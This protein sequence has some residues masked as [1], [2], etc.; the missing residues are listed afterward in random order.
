MPSFPSFI[1]S[2]WPPGAPCTLSNLLEESHNHCDYSVYCL[3][4]SCW[5]APLLHPMRHNDTSRRVRSPLH[6]YA[7]HYNVIHI[8]LG[9]KRSHSDFIHIMLGIKL[10]RSAI[11]NIQ[12]E[13]GRIH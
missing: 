11:M 10:C 6:H 4:C 8:M 13:N 3:C 12:V 7:V 5:A 2:A 9:V 1:G